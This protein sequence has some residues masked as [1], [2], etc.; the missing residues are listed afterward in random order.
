MPYGPNGQWR[1]ADPGACA[2]HVAKIATGEIEEIYEPPPPD[3]NTMMLREAAQVYGR[4]G[5]RA[6]A[7][8]LTPERRREIAKTAAEARWRR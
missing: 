3:E 8:L 5:G 4:K 2:V 1:P 7:A 6:R